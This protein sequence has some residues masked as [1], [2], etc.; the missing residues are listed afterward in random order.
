MFVVLTVM[1][2]VLY[3]P[4]VVL[5]VLREHA[6]V[7]V[8]E[9]ALRAEVQRQTAAIENARKLI[10]AFRG[11]PLVNERLAQIDLKYQR[12]GEEIVQV[13]LVDL[14]VPTTTGPAAATILDRDLE[15]V[16]VGWPRWSR[17]AESWARERGLIRLYLM[18][19]VRVVLLLMSA[20]LLVAAFV[21]YPPKGPRRATEQ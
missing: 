16:P 4:A 3:A 18:P 17:E 21:L 7:L 14:G 11:D 8:E 20:G 9:R 19:G 13:P 1:A 6:L 15:L 5:P 12:E 10:D 2:F